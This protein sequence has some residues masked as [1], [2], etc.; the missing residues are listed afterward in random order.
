MECLPRKEEE[1]ADET[2]SS[3]RKNADLENRRQNSEKSSSSSSRKSSLASSS[4]KS[5]PSL[6]IPK[7]PDLLDSKNEDEN[8]NRF[9]DNQ[10]EFEKEHKSKFDSIRQKFNQPGEYHLTGSISKR[11]MNLGKYDT[12]PRP[13]KP[14]KP[15][16][17]EILP[18]KRVEQS[19]ETSPKEDIPNSEPPKS[20][21][22]E[23]LDG[24]MDDLA[25]LL[26]TLDF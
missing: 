16:K 19:P 1:I 10:E 17:K 4:T 24:N 21:I 11:G 23:Q 6:L 15:V 9:F 2:K 7:T 25:K 5:Q 14:A 26:K 22:M 20:P 12:L 13:K 8:N 3:E 18:E